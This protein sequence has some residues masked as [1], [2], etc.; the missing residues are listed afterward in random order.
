L[1]GSGFFGDDR[2]N[3]EQ[4]VTRALSLEDAQSPMDV[5]SLSRSWG[6]TAYSCCV[7]F[8]FSLAVLFFASPLAIHRAVESVLQIL[9]I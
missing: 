9:H 4:R 1:A 3:F 5:E 6:R 8:V 2:E 7:V